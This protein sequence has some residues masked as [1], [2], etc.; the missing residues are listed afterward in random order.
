[1]KKTH[2]ILFFEIIY[3]LG[4]FL[5]ALLVGNVMDSIEGMFNI[6][7]VPAQLTI[8]YFVVGGV[9]A[10]FLNSFLVALSCIL[11][12]YLSKATLNGTSLMAFF[13]TVGFSFFG[14]NFINIW[15]CILGTWLFT[16]IS[17]K[18]FSSQINI[19]L[20]ATALSP[21]VSEMIFRYP[22]IDNMSIKVLMGI[23]IGCIAGF[24]LPILCRHGLNLHKGYSLYN[25]ASVAGFIGILLF[26]FLYRFQNV[27]VPTNTYLGHESSLSAVI[28]CFG[29]YIFMIFFGFYLNDKS[30]KGYKKLLGISGYQCDFVDSFNVGLTLINIGIFGIFTSI[31]YLL[32]NSSFISPTIGSMI[33]F[34]ALAPCGAH[35]LNIL[36]IMF[37]YVFLSLFGFFDLN[38]QAMIVAICFSGSLVPITGRYGILMGMIAGMLHAILVTTVV[39]FH[40][41]FVLYNGGYTAGITAIILVPVLEYFFDISEQLTLLPK[42]KKEFGND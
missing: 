24:L 40:G 9:G 6:F 25:A 20:F 4:L 32:I 31:Y 30:F 17:K 26:S 28:F 3:G 34:L 2:Q 36:P 19:A 42:I 39:T 11:L 33:C 27:E 35:I 14:I 7:S 15:P 1:M 37:G 16:K 23:L 18:P 12:Q 29:T 13:L 38:A 41:G 10:S 5:F 22:G 8:D 21:F